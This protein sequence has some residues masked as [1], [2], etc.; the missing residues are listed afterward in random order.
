LLASTNSEQPL[1]IRTEGVA[2]RHDEEE[3]RAR[4]VLLVDDHTLFR[5]VLA[6]I[7]KAHASL[8][9]DVQA[10][11]LDEARRALGA[12]SDFAL[13]VV[14]LDLPDEGGFELIGEL[15]RAGI[16]ALALTTNYDP[17]RLAEASGPGVS[18]AL[19]TAASYDEILGAIRG[20]ADG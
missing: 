6:V 2:R 20:L 1:S 17:E 18:V 8:G 14:D 11:S 19:T 10:G 4:R 12:R 15:R 16:P 13:A 5:E 3:A 7:C 9:E